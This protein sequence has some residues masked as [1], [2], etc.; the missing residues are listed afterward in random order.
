MSN[1]PANITPIN[2]SAADD[3]AFIRSEVKKSKGVTEGTVVRFDRVKLR[4]IRPAGVPEGARI[5]QTEAVGVEEFITTYAALYVGGRWY[6]TGSQSE[7]AQG[8]PYTSRQFFDDV[9][10]HAATR[11]VQIATKFE[12]VEPEGEDE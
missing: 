1:T 11:N 5:P 9:I 8:Q 4:R 10:G 2:P 3:L 7:T 6:V 12:A